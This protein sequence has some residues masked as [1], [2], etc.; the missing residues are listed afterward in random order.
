MQP[1][2]RSGKRPTATVTSPHFD[3]WVDWAPLP[4]GEQAALCDVAAP[5][6]TRLQANL[7]STRTVIGLSLFPQLHS[8][9]QKRHVP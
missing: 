2:V 8:A 6:Y 1:A 3:V 5:T 9:N 7:S 4:S